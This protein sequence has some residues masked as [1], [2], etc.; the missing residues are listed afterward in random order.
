MYEY[1]EWNDWWMD[2]SNGWIEG[3]SVMNQ[4]YRKERGFLSRSG[5]MDDGL[6]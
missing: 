5:R 2:D 3:E 4:S 6:R 1:D